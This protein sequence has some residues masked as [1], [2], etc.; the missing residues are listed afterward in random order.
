[1]R[2]MVYNIRYAAGVGRKFHMPFPF[3]GFLKRTHNNLKLIGEFIKSQNPDIIGLIEVDSGS[4]RSN[5]NNQAEAIA[6][7]LSHEHVF[8]SKYSSNS[9]AQKIPLLN[10][11]GN[12][13]LTNQ[14]IVDQKSHYFNKGI[15][16]LVIE[17]ELEDLVVFLVH[18]SIKYRH[19]H[20][21]LKDLYSL[22]KDIQKPLIVAGD[23]NSFWGD[24]E[25]SLFM[26]AAGLK[27]VNDT[28]IPS[29][30]SRA[31]RRQLDYILHSPEISV[32]KFFVPQVRFSDHVPLICDFDVV[33]SHRQIPEH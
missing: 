9:L 2:M 8:D 11:Q 10:K 31:P 6:A 30:P 4:Y 12:A 7:E 29:H 3:S 24:E 33:S 14:V 27:N 20:N 21:Q 18:L 22:I 23:F 26:A 5:R 28:G 16:R 17:L 15:K 19:R 13:L 32:R 25:L 1:M